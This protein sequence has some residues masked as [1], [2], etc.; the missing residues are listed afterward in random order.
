MNK[1]CIN[2]VIWIVCLAMLFACNQ[3]KE[4]KNASVLHTSYYEISN[5][6]RTD[7]T[8]A[9]TKF[10]SN[11][12]RSEL[13]SFLVDNDAFL[14]NDNLSP[15]N[16]DWY[17]LKSLVE[18]NA[19]VDCSIYIDLPSTASWRMNT[20]IKKELTSW[21]EDF[22]KELRKN[23]VLSSPFRKE[24][25]ESDFRAQLI[26]AYEDSN[27]VSFSFYISSYPAG[28][29]HGMYEFESFNFNKTTGERL[30]FYDLFSVDTREDSVLMCDLITESIGMGRLDHISVYEYDF[31]L[32]EDY[33][34]FN[35]DAYELGL[36][37]FGTPRAPLNRRAM[38]ARFGN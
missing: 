3:R 37:G 29:V 25:M 1:D 11:F 24:G 16:C 27:Y 30:S 6:L 18:Y 23:D 26:S 22:L 13:D 38:F 15:V 35:F 9:R 12:Q 20:T 8:A 7:S 36:Y 14:R 32:N 33:I 34:V 10:S 31:N 21:K 5:L 17:C 2:N 28:A 19:A 4:S